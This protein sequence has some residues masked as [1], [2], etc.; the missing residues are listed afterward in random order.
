MSRGIKDRLHRALGPG[1]RG[2]RQWKVGHT[3]IRMQRRPTPATASRS[4]RWSGRIKP[5]RTMWAR[6]M[7]NTSTSTT[8]APSLRRWRRRRIRPAP[9]L[10]LIGFFCT[11]NPDH[12]PEP[13]RHCDLPG[14]AS[15]QLPDQ[16]E[17][18]V[19]DS[20]LLTSFT[21]HPSCPPRSLQPLRRA[22]ARAQAAVHPAAA[23][24]HSGVQTSR[25]VTRL[26]PTS[27]AR[28]IRPERWTRLVAIPETARSGLLGLIVG[29][30]VHHRLV[31]VQ[32]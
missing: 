20:R 12:F 15:E 6:S 5:C 4:K 3:V 30:V 19:A 16:P 31:G 9:G 23:I 2:F 13:R 25:P 32:P 27:P 28:P 14:T 10:L 22:R 8:M 17:V 29:A 11:L 18:P 1:R 7:A 26:R 24:P 21:V